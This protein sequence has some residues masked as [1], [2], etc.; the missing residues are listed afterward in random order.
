MKKHILTGTF[1][2]ACAGLIY[3]TAFYN[4]SI[5]GGVVSKHESKGEFK[6]FIPTAK[7]N[8]YDV[9]SR[10]V[11]PQQAV[12]VVDNTDVVANNNQYV[13]QGNA[14]VTA[15][16]PSL[17]EP[18]N[19][20]KVDFKEYALAADKQQ[21]IQNA[22]TG[23]SLIIQPNSFLNELGEVAEG[24]VH[25]FMREMHTAP[26]FFMRGLPMNGFES[27]GVIELKATG[28]DGNTL[29]LNNEKPVEVLMA[30]ANAGTNYS[31]YSLNE[32]N[33][34]WQIRNTPVTLMKPQVQTKKKANDFDTNISLAPVRKGVHVFKKELR[35]K[36]YL[37]YRAY[38]EMSAY[39][40]VEWV[41]TGKNAKTIRTEL[42]KD[43][44]NPY[45]SRRKSG[46]LFNYWNDV[47]LS[48][49]D[50]G[51][52]HMIFT[53]GS[54]VLDIDV[55]PEHIYGRQINADAMY[56]EY[57]TA[58]SLKKPDANGV[59]E[60]TADTFDPATLPAGYTSLSKFTIDEMGVWGLNQH[61]QYNNTLIAPSVSFVDENGTVLKAGKL[62]QYDAR[63]NTYQETDLSSILSVNYNNLNNNLVFVVISENEVAVLE[64]SA[65]DDLVKKSDAG[66]P[67]SIKMARRKIESA[68]DVTAL[69]KS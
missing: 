28:E 39:S 69:F 18:I 53:N 33:R 52:L 58:Y 5:S 51:R 65:F 6:N 26:E 64:K 2:A 56:D 43:R 20:A 66:Y 31:V 45:G 36:T 23:T 3:F 67:L 7:N 35:F 47:K 42:L 62:F 9:F 41:Y 13:Q 63:Y 46:L 30:S 57:K 10:F 37:N 17:I 48:K 15:V 12:A 19:T 61:L 24:T 1:V 68:N 16:A 34:S 60:E 49:D 8:Q 21:T 29:Y 40:D 38:P 4:K 25:L 11:K 54:E 44:S 50:N 55:K 32:S 22:A 14:S 59:V 27:A